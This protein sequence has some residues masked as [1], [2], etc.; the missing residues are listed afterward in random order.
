MWFQKRTAGGD[1]DKKH[2]PKD[3]D[4]TAANQDKPRKP[5]SPPES[6]FKKLAPSKDR[7]TLLKDEL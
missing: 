7:Y 6:T 2:I 3:G 4:D 5:T 1:G